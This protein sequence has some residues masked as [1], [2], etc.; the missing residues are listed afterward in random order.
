MTKAIVFTEYGDPDV[1]RLVDVPTPEPGP[2]QVRVRMKAAGVQPT[3]TRTRSG[4]WRAWMPVRFPARLGNGASS[5]LF[6]AAQRPRR[7]RQVDELTEVAMAAADRD[8]G[9]GGVDA[10]SPHHPL[11]D[12]PLGIQFRSKAC[13]SDK[14]DGN[15]GLL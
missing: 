10:R 8:D 11:I 4:A 12:R 7:S 5:D 14:T 6:G 13:A 9:A 2:G 1:L 3:D 15:S